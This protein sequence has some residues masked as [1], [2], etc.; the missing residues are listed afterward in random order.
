MYRNKPMPPEGTTAMNTI[1]QAAA[2]AIANVLNQA[3]MD[4]HVQ[5][6]AGRPVWINATGA[7]VVAAAYRVIG[8]GGRLSEE[9]SDVDWLMVSFEEAGGRN[10]F[11][12]GE[13][14]FNI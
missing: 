11:S 3:S 5:V 1:S 7:Q 6:F 14:R 10:G 12:S 4:V 2:W 8:E 9:L 13:L